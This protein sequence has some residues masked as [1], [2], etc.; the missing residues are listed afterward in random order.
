MG[1]VGSRL[2][3]L[4]CL[5]CREVG[6]RKIMVGTRMAKELAE[7]SGELSLEGLHFWKTA[8]SAMTHPAT[9]ITSTFQAQGAEVSEK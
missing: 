7:F 4:V 2:I 8:F 9:T 3:T 1:F 5:L 6:G